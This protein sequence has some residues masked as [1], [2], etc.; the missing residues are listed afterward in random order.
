MWEKTQVVVSIV[1]RSEWLQFKLSSIHNT[2]TN[3]ALSGTIVESAS[4]NIHS[5]YTSE[6]ERKEL[7]GA[8]AWCFAPNSWWLTTLL[9]LPFKVSVYYLIYI[10]AFSV[11]AIRH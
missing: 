7:H 4:L 11:C 1:A 10:D 8:N 9:A 6:V 5:F 3:L 2:R